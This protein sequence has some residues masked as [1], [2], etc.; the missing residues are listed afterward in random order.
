MQSLRKIFQKVKE[1][2]MPHP[3]KHLKQKYKIEQ[4]LK[5]FKEILVRKKYKIGLGG[6]TVLLLFSKKR[7]QESLENR[8]EQELYS[9]LSKEQK[10][11]NFFISFL[12]QSLIE[13]LQDNQSKREGAQFLEEVS[14]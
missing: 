13:V 10:T 8:L 9:N 4:D 14:K 5:D 11:F 1:Y 3:I 6:C 12:K 2:G 7:I